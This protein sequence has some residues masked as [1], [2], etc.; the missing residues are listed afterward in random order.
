MTGTDFP[1]MRRT[2]LSFPKQ[3]H[4]LMGGM[5]ALGSNRQQ[6][7]Q[8]AFGRIA[9]APGFQ[10][11]SLNSH[12]HQLSLWIKL[13][14]F[15][16]GHTAGQ[17]VRLLLYLCTCRQACLPNAPARLPNYSPHPKLSSMVDILPLRKS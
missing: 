12:P 1:Y 10:V 7:C 11:L 13:F 6:M 9:A 4:A 8:R 5:A 15:L 16:H 3:Q 14:L 17:T 2:R